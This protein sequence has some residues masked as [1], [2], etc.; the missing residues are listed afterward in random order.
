[1]CNSNSFYQ[2]GSIK[3]ICCCAEL[4]SQAILTQGNACWLTNLPQE[5]LNA[6]R[7]R[8][9]CGRIEVLDNRAEAVLN[10]AFTAALPRLILHPKNCLLY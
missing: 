4:T 9:K 2:P 1:M 3:G 6:S 5:Q 8:I 7:E 10:E